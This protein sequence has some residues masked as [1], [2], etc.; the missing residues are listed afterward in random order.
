MRNHALVLY[1]GRPACVKE[2]GDRIELDL[3]DGKSQRVREKDIVLLHEGPCELSRLN[4]TPDPL[5]DLEVVRDLLYDQGPSNLQELAELLYGDFSPA[6]AW[7]TWQIVET[8]VHFSAESPSAIASRSSEEVASE[9]ERQQ[10]RDRERQEWDEFLERLRH[11]QPRESDGVHL[12]EVE[13]LATEA[14]AGSRI[15][16]ALG[17]SENAENAHALLLEIGWWSVARLPYPA[18]R[19]LN[20]EPPAVIVTGDTVPGEDRVDLTHLEALAIDDEGNRDPDDALSVDDAGALWVHV[21]DVSSLVPIDSEVD[22]MAR[23]R[24]ATLYLPEGSVPMLPP[25]LLQQLGLGLQPE[26]ASPALSF[27]LELDAAGHGAVT[28]ITPSLVSVRRMTY[29]EAEK[30]FIDNRTLQAAEELTGRS[31]ARRIA[32][33]ALNMQWPEVRI[34]V[35]DADTEPKV[36]LEPLVP[37]QSREIV[38]ESMILAGEAAAAFAVECKLPFPFSVQEEVEDEEANEEIPEGL[39]GAFALRRRQRP[40]RVS[41]MPG[42]HSGLGVEAYARCTSPLRRY[43]DLVAHQQLRAAVTGTTPMVETEL[44]E[45]VGA[46]ES[47]ARAVRSVERQCNRHWTLVHLQRLPQRWS[48]RAIVV[49]TR[50][51]RAHVVLPD[52]GLETQMHLREEPALNEELNVVAGEI[53]L[54]RLDLHLVLGDRE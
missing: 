7:A 39:T 28:R 30:Q 49:D 21:A 17:R 10:R 18:R 1:R 34:R 51:T 54:A 46:A 52:L 16:Q 27:R 19:G 32:D 35:D 33:G 36:R 8:G 5:E 25:K 41:A 44:L 11:G 37:F 43:T 38:A 20:L 2:L 29:A 22:E 45:R 24:G 50:R 26:T 6:I 40:S 48:G 31:R 3:G 13:D 12:R 15:L 42:R 9:L 53:D 47:V 14:R 23:T 4:S